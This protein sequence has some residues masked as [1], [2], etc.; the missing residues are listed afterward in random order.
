VGF[1]AFYQ[2]IFSMTP[3]GEWT[4]GN[5]INGG[6]LG[7]LAYSFVM[8]FGTL[9]CD[10]LESANPK[11][12]ITNSLWCI[13]QF[14]VFGWLFFFEWTGYKAEWQFS[15]YAMTTP[16]VVFSTGLAFLAFLFFFILCDIY[17]LRVPQLS[18]LGQN[19]L[20]IYILQAVL[21]IVVNMYIPAASPLWV[22]LCTFAGVYAVCYTVAWLMNWRGIIV[23]I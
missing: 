23:K 21:V 12:T 3:Y 4:V 10:I 2:L 7:P 13:I 5:S 16:Y 15:Q 19:P 8:L 1:L 11:K 17:K 22:A 20:V 9:V 6:P 14:C 18:I